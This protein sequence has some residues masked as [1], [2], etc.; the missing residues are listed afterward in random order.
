M[1]LRSAYFSDEDL[2]TCVAVIQPFIPAKVATFLKV[3]G[4]L[5]YRKAVTD[6]H[7]KVLASKAKYNFRFSI[8]ADAVVTGIEK[9]IKKVLL[10][11]RGGEIGHGLWALPGGFV[12]PDEK[13]FTGCLRELREETGIHLWTA[14]AQRILRK[15][16]VFDNPKR[17]LRGRIIS[18]AFHFDLGDERLPEINAGDDAMGAVWV[19][20][21]DLLKYLPLFLKTMR[22]FWNIS[23]GILINEGFNMIEVNTGK[24]LLTNKNVVAAT[25]SIIDTQL[26]CKNILLYDNDGIVLEDANTQFDIADYLNLSLKYYIQFTEFGVIWITSAKGIVALS[27][28]LELKV[29]PYLEIM[30]DGY[31]DS[32][33]TDKEISAIQS[34]IIRTELDKY[35][36]NYSKELVLHTELCITM[37]PF[38]LVLNLNI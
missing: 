11:Q 2:D 21:T 37:N 4:K 18:H 1:H 7:S 30:L 38:S 6:E 3:W 29:P 25:C 9:G 19:N 35:I 26:Q 17:S 14:D 10:I 27:A 16:K 23:W 36:G 24:L 33:L 28:S 31:P 8:A 22:L 5:P 20:V 15:E 34:V 32:V 12:E 13:I